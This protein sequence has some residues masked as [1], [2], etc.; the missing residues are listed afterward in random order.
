MDMDFTKLIEDV[1]KNESLNNDHAESLILYGIAANEL[2]LALAMG[3]GACELCKVLE[4]DGIR[5][6]D[7]ESEA[8]QIELNKKP[9]WWWYWHTVFIAEESLIRIMQRSI[10]KEVI[11]AL[12][13]LG[14]IEKFPH[15]FDS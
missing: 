9:K 2:A 8:E 12:M 13:F 10:L 14:Y 6:A 5:S 4:S 7:S 11:L 1:L 3:V 15:G